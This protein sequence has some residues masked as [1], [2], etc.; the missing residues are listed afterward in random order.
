MQQTAAFSGLRPVAKALGALVGETNRRGM[1][2]WAVIESSRTMRYMAG[3]S[4]SVTGYAC[5]ERIASLSLF[6]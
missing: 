1:G 4:A 3:W 6:Q 5:I 2:C